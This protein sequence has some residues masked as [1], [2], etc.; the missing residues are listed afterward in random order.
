MNTILLITHDT[1]ISGAPKSILLIFE[2]LVKKG[3]KIT[4]IALNGG[5]ALEKRF[6]NISL[7]YYRLDNIS[8]K[9]E[10]SY[11]NRFKK[12][13][14]GIPFSSKLELIKNKLLSDKFDYIYCNTIVSLDF[15]S[16]FF[17]NYNKKFILH[18]HELNTVIEEFCPNLSEYKDIIDIFIVPSV[19]NKKSLVENHSIYESKIKIIREASDIKVN[20]NDSNLNE[21]K[22]N[23]IMCGG[24]YWRKG[25]DLFIL[26]ADAILKK[27]KNFNFFWIGYQS[28]E[29]KR[30][31]N[32]DLIKLDI[33]NHVH[34]INESKDLNDWYQKCDLFL[35]SSREDPFPLA[36]IDAGI[37]G[38]PIFC[39]DK[40]TGIAEVI[41]KKC[42][43]P[44]LNIHEMSLRILNMVSNLNEY[45]IIS[46]ENKKIFGKF[47][48]DKISDEVF[49]IL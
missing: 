2:N 37:L 3:F 40:A 6:E 45:K 9:T 20:K 21:N 24:A 28:E 27:N 22:I 8:K 4:T 5:G 13:V 44:Y 34:F 14:F 49:K 19:L 17:N 47:T 1:S 33:K 46:E 35:L 43:V 12:K 7:N 11:K 31:N 38:I 39:F 23:I 15:A 26:I 29:R 41:N 16:L 10:Y 30:V 36:A 42:V 18:I 48:A 25:D 32:A